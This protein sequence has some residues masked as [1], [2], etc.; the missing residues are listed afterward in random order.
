[1][2][3]TAKTITNIREDFVKGY[4]VILPTL[5]NFHTVKE[6]REICEKQQA[7]YKD[8]ADTLETH[9]LRMACRNLANILGDIIA[10]TYFCDT[11]EEVVLKCAISIAY[12][13]I[14]HLGT[15]GKDC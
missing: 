2:S 13:D 6:L 15:G 14:L 12:N 1:M 5:S 7:R 3:N 8:L 10:E 11:V 9:E 4:K